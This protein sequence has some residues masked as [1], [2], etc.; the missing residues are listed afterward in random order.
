MN[1]LWVVFLVVER[2]DY[3]EGPDLIGALIIKFK[4]FFR[5]WRYYLSK[6]DNAS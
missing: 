3:P 2:D 4:S 1:D 6:E 5:E